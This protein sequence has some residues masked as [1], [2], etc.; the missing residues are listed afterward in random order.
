MRLEPGYT[1]Q[2]SLVLTCSMEDRPCSDLLQ[3][4]RLNFP[5]VDQVRQVQLQQFRVERIPFLSG[6]EQRH[7]WNGIETVWDGT[8]TVWN[9]TGTLWDGTETCHGHKTDD[10]ILFTLVE[11]KASSMVL[12]LIRNISRALFLSMCLRRCIS[13]TSL[14]PQERRVDSTSQGRTTVMFGSAR[15]WSPTK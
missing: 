6:M 5:V 12:P 13:T 9:G 14:C 4:L 8:G 2:N 3:F 11:L 7:E 15:G 10:I 1:I